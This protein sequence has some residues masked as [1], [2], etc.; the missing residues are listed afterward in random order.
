MEIKINVKDYYNIDITKNL[1]IQIVNKTN[2][3]I[4][5]SYKNCDVAIANLNS[6]SYDI[7]ISSKNTIFE[8]FFFVIVDN[9]K[10]LNSKGEEIPNNIEVKEN[11]RGYISIFNSFYENKMLDEIETAFKLNILIEQDG[12]TRK[13]HFFINDS[14]DFKASLSDGLYT[15]ESI[16]KRS[17][18]EDDN[19]VTFTEEEKLYT[20]VKFR[21]KNGELY[22]RNKSDFLYE[23]GQ[24]ILLIKRKRN[25]FNMLIKSP[26]SSNFNQK[27]FIKLVNNANNRPIYI[28]IKNSSASSY[29]NYGDYFIE[30]VY[31]DGVIYKDLYDKVSI[32]PHKQLLNNESTSNKFLK[33]NLPKPNLSIKILDKHTKAYKDKCVVSILN[34]K[35]NENILLYNI[36][37]KKGFFAK[38]HLPAGD[39]IVN[40]IDAGTFNIPMDHEFSILK[41]E[42][43]KI[44]IET[45]LENTKE[46]Y[47]NIL[48]NLIDSINNNEKK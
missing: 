41:N 34:K 7:L 14:G 1:M 29:L 10:I 17:L 19:G 30:D 38:A 45:K 39:Y 22:V 44:N 12:N 25:N 6:G 24:K 16:N 32:A 13:Q 40:S 47:Q 3:S 33:L 28:D 23:K 43:L 9:E 46:L 2:N 15:I 11:V 48:K 4:V 21:L 42:D 5:G 18:I 27:N 20:N 26:L 37:Y 8:N 36:Q 31:I 35:T